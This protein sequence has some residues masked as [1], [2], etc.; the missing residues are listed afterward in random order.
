MKKVSI[1]LPTYNGESFIKESISSILNQTYP[2]WELI[3]VNDCSSDNTLNIANKY[4]QKDSRIKVI[5]N[6]KNL[7]LPASLNVGFHHATGDYY[8]WTSDDNMY[9]PTAIEKMVKYLDENS[10]C[11]L[12]S[13]NFDFI[14]EDNCFENQFTDL[15]PDRNTLQLTE[16]CNIGA[17]FMYRKEIAEKTGNYDE[18]MFCAEDYDYWCRIALIGNINYKD[19]NLYEYRNHSKSLTATKQKTIQEKTLEIRFKYAEPIMAKFNLSNTEK[20]KK[21]LG[22]YYKEGK[23]KKWLETAYRIDSK[24]ARKYTILFKFK[25]LLK[26]FFYVKNYKNEKYIKFFFI[27]KTIPIRNA[28]LSENKKIFLNHNVRKQSV[29]IVEPNR[30]HSEILPAFIKYFQDLNYNVDLILRCENMKDLPFSDL[31]GVN[32][33]QGEA[34][35]IKEMLKTKKIREYDFVFFSSSA[36]WEPGNKKQSYLQ[37]LNFIPKAKKGILMVEHNIIPYLAEYNEEKYLKQKRLF[38]CSELCD[39]PMLSPSYYGNF[40]ITQKSADNIVRFIVVGAVNQNLKDIK[41]LLDSAKLLIKNNIKNFEIII[42]GKG[43]ASVPYELQ[44]NITNNGRVK[45]DKLYSDMEEADYILFLLD[46]K[47][48]LHERY[49]QGTTTG[50]L[51]LSLGFKTLSIVNE[52][53]AKIYKLND[54]NAIIYNGDNLYNAMKYAIELPSEKYVEKQNNLKAMAEKVYQKSL[55]NLEEAIKLNA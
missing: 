54:E 9:K 44:D 35:H 34:S 42:D 26:K 3:I 55:K 51:N 17:C 6:E 48:P 19:E 12:V 2:Y 27:K 18:T 31:S 39:V 29:L 32:I 15:V 11:D 45:F 33:F 20:I 49:K 43:L 16:R 1:I 46:E 22:F 8:T 23:N 53:F 5:S 47:N 10:D 37:Y 41:L 24:S 14:T 28:G 50:S 36:F 25:S 30:Y 52:S 13:F 38:S 40:K 4:A 7:K 21:F